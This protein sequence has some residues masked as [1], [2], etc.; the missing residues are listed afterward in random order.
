MF[1]KRD[2]IMLKYVSMGKGQEKVAEE[3]ITEASDKGRWV[4]IDNLHLVAKWMDSL[5]KI[6]LAFDENYVFLF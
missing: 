1:G 5:E 3:I 2:G 6:I 4:L